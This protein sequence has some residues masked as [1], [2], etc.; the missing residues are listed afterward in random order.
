MIMVLTE[1]DCFSNL[2]VNP[3]NTKI[4]TSE[5]RGLYRFISTVFDASGAG[6]DK[7]Y[8]ETRIFV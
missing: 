6:I 8:V 7:R 4:F 3:Q 1:I 2:Q 5:K